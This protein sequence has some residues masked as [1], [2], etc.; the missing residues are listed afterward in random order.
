LYRWKN[1]VDRGW[2]K[3]EIEMWAKI[4]RRKPSDYNRGVFPSTMVLVL[5]ELDRRPVIVIIEELP[6]LP[7]VFVFRC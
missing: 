1:I 6:F 5:Q 2:P 7:D 3:K 4:F